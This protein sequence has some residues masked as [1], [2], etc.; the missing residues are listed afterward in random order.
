MDLSQRWTYEEKEI[1]KRGVLAYGY[2][3][4][5]K[6]KRE[7]LRT[8]ERKEVIAFAN[9]FLRCLVDN[10]SQECNELQNFLLGIIEEQ[11]DD[12]YVAPSNKDWE[13]VGQSARA[14]PWA[15]RIQLL[16]RIRVLIKKFKK[17]QQ[18]EQIQVNWSTLLNFI[19]DQVLMGQ[20]PSVWWSRQ[21]DIDLL[22]GI[23][24]Y[25]YANYT[26][27]RDCPDYS[28]YQH[29]QNNIYN[30]FPSS[31][32]S[33]RRLK[34]LMAAIMRIENEK[35]RLNFEM[36]Q[37]TDNSLEGWTQKEVRLLFSF[38]NSYGIPINND[39]KTNWIELKERF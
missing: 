10:L 12:L 19:P 21:H 23:Y 24:K 2:G 28:F 36:E 27:I 5:D 22:R 3:R 11:A 29:E 13:I 26:E 39:A 34:K 31:D 15:R 38:M 32:N 8:K 37:H 4:W 14:V 25:G 33:T 16:F 17:K 7:R 9:A 30:D 1:L 18:Q 35:G 6:L 20:R